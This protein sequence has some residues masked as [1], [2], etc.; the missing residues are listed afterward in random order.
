MSPSLLAKRSRARK[1]SE[2]GAKEGVPLSGS[3]EKAAM[4]REEAKLNRQRD[5]SN[6]PSYFLN[7]PPYFLNRERT[8][9]N[10]SLLAKN[11][12]RDILNRQLLT[13]D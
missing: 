2:S 12:P 9:M 3:R 5:I 10:R 8:A 4:N 13:K 1:M 11:P 6:R 7:R